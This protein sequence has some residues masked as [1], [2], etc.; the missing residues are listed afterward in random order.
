MKQVGILPFPLKE[1]TDVRALPGS[2]DRHLYL[3]LYSELRLRSWGT[4]CE[5]C[6]GIVGS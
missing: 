6:T 1:K 3:R 5:G 4:C 2:E